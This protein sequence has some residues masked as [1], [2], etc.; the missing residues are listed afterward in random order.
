MTCRR[1][2][3]S[4]AAAAWSRLRNHT[5]T[6]PIA[7][8]E[9]AY[10]SAT[11]E[12][13]PP[14]EQGRTRP[15]GPLANAPEGSALVDAPLSRPNRRHRLHVRKDDL[16]ASVKAFLD[17]NPRPTPFKNN[18]PGRHWYRAFLKR[19][20]NL[21]K[22][23]PEAVSKA[24]SNVSEK[25]IRKWFC[26]IEQYLK[27][28][29]YFDIHKDPTRVF[30]G[31][32]TCFLLCPKEDK[33]IAPLM[34]TFS[35]SGAI[36]PPMVI[37]PYKRLPTNIVNSVPND[38]G[39]GTSDNG[40]MKSEVILIALYPNAT[41]ILQPADVS[42]FKPLKNA[43][44]LAVLEWRRN[45]PF[46]ELTKVH[47]APILKDAL[48]TLK[49]SS[50][51]NGFKTC[52]LC[53]WNVDNIN[54]T[55]C[56]G[57]D[58]QR[59]TNS[60]TINR[61]NGT[62]TCDDFINIVGP[63]KLKQLKEYSGNNTVT[64]D[65]KLLLK[66]FRKVQK[67]EDGVIHEAEHEVN[68]SV[69]RIYDADLSESQEHHEI[70]TED[71]IQDMHIH[72]AEH[73]VNDPVIRIYDADLSESQEHH[74]IL[75][76][77]NIQ[78][79]EVVFDDGNEIIYEELTAREIIE[80]TNQ[81][82]TSGVLISRNKT[83]PHG[84]T[85]EF[86]LS[87]S[88]QT[89]RT[90]NSEYFLLQSE[91]EN[92]ENLTPRD[93]SQEPE[94]NNIE[95]ETG[96][97]DYSVPH[98]FNNHTGAHNKL[99]QHLLWQKTPERKNQR[100]TERL[101]YVITSS[102]WKKIHEEKETKKLE[103]EKK[104][105]ENKR[106]RELIAVA[107]AANP[108]PMKKRAHVKNLTSVITEPKNSIVGPA[109]IAASVPDNWD[110]GMTD[111][112]WMKSKKYFE[113]MPI[114]IDVLNEEEHI[115]LEDVPEMYES[116]VNDIL[117]SNVNVP[118]VTNIEV[119]ITKFLASTVNDQSTP[120]IENTHVIETRE[121]IENNRPS[122]DLDRINQSIKE[123]SRTY[124]ELKDCLM[125]PK[126]PERK[127]KRQVERL[128]FVISSSGWKNIYEDKQKEKEEK[129]KEKEERHVTSLTNY[130]G[131]DMECPIQEDVFL[132]PVTP[133]TTHQQD[134]VPNMLKHLN[135]GTCPTVGIQLLTPILQPVDQN[136]ILLVPVLGD[137]IDITESCPNAIRHVKLKSPPCIIDS[138]IEGLPDENVFLSVRAANFQSIGDLA[139]YLTHIVTPLGPKMASDASK[140][141]KSR[142]PTTPNP[143]STGD[144]R[145]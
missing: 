37:Y 13:A 54:F 18:N 64:E 99:Q 76:E 19:H 138:V 108:N 93:N 132:S 137:P 68:D 119:D 30:N 65:F 126:T 26:N 47:F 8:T 31:D 71:N 56:L 102:G 38:W 136:K 62:L 6:E 16:Q 114:I 134:C 107:K 115:E 40:W 41:R 88:N 139:N 104:K 117:E 42:C 33:V 100:Q 45:H 60:D 12:Q 135:T 43:W 143:G 23:T 14:T 101:P 75:T 66:I 123:T 61:E 50:I 29:Q 7:A 79:M 105:E 78:D 5:F 17:G 130:L 87:I 15:D 49:T 109:S 74:E 24:S 32:E 28:K 133:T 121:H 21:A 145:I 81:P 106:K 20:P 89:V 36:T 144:L 34:F 80:D 98:V 2:T 112:G 72:E 67:D 3:S 48:S 91:L 59:P 22:R 127:N 25:D 53:P 58:M 124:S 92:K 118:F 46:L 129:E 39:I 77:D 73:E 94:I 44:K 85:E 27:E 116:T 35:A 131:M 120:N 113:D 83:L 110:I 84:Y 4:A 128:P 9:D 97:L 11:P 90:N 140:V 86:E 95:L 52:G 103:K 69:I 63:E 82:S 1:D 111:K 125:W 96:K 51:Y 141:I 57:K 142:T 10:D 55:K 122:S 70:L